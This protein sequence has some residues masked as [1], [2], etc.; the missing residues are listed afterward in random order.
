MKNKYICKVTFKNSIFITIFKNNYYFN[1]FENINIV[2]F[3]L[4]ERNQKLN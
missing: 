2:K 4:K 3:S 1:I